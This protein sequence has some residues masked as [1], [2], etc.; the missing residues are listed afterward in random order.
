MIWGI[1]ASLMTTGSLGAVLVVG[2]PEVSV[3]WI[4]IAVVAMTFVNYGIMARLH[5]DRGTHK[6]RLSVF[7]NRMSWSLTNLKNIFNLRQGHMPVMDSHTERVIRQAIE[8]LD[9]DL[10]AYRA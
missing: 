4:G 6:R 9:A 5:M 2:V 7:M 1:I 8:D 10:D 3:V